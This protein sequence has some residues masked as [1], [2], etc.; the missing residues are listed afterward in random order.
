MLLAEMRVALTAA[1]TVVW[2][3]VTMDYKKVLK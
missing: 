2:M 3:V 1:L